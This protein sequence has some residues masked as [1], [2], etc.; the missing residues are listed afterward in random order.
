MYHLPVAGSYSILGSW[1]DILLLIDV[2]VPLG[3]ATPKS[4][5]LNV[6]PLEPLLFVD[7]L[8]PPLLEP[9]LFVPPLFWL[10]LS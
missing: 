8:E 1:T 2:N 3:L 7:E 10:E 5:P 6:V 4:V 9:L